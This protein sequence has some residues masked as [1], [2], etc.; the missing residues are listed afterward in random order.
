MC[1]WV[2]SACFSPKRGASWMAG[3][4]ILAPVVESSYAATVCGG[5]RAVAAC[6]LAKALYVMYLWR[7][8]ARPLMDLADAFTQVSQLRLSECEML[9]SQDLPRIAQ[10]ES[11]QDV[12]CRARSLCSSILLGI[13]QGFDFAMGRDSSK[14]SR[15]AE[16]TTRGFCR[17]WGLKPERLEVCRQGS[18]P[19]RSDQYGCWLSERETLRE[20]P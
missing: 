12:G 8:F 11:G 3:R 2:A 16:D 6:W 9:C 15:C 17:T 10:R 20:N 18:C 19:S 7:R 5:P 1:W 13:T 4:D 14:H